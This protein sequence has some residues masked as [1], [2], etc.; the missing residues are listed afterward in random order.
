MQSVFV[1]L[2]VLPLVATA[3]QQSMYT[4][5][6]FNGLA[7]NPAYAGTGDALSASALVRRQWVGLEGAPTTETISVHAPVQSKNIGLGLTVSMDQ[8]AVTRQTGVYGAY[9]Y[10]IPVRNG[11]LSAGLQVGFSAVRADYSEVYTLGQ[12]PTFQQLYSQFLP[13]AGVGLFYYNSVF[14]AGLSAPLLIEN[15][16]ESNGTD[17]FTQRRHYFFTSGM[18]FS[19]SDGVKAKPNILVKVVEG[20]PVSVDYNVNFLLNNTVWLG[21]SYR[22]PESINFLMELNINKRF[23]VGYAYDHIIQNTLKTVTTSSH[24]ILLNYRVS[25]TKKGV[26]NPR[27]F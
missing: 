24:E 23:R 21:V 22:G 7:I 1:F 5:Y 15:K 3:Q 6:M 4:Q 16:M 25:L 17:I 13:N 27:T 20:S 18:V 14:Y 10:R 8:I 12:D 9:S 26:V 11:Y 2:L 19:L